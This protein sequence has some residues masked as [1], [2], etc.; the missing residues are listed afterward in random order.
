MHEVR[1]GKVSTNGL[2]KLVEV[3]KFRTTGAQILEPFLLRFLMRVSMAIR[4]S[5]ELVKVRI[6]EVR[7]TQSSL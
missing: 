3:Q 6:T 7:I 2:T 1:I 4:I 5:F